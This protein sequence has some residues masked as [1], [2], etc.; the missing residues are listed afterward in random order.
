MPGPTY[1]VAELAA[2]LDLPFRGQ[3][4]ELLTGL[5]PLASAGKG[6]LSF[7]SSVKFKSSLEQSAASAVIVHPDMADL[8]P[9]NVLLSTNPYLSY[10]RVSA[11]FDAWQRPRL[12]IHPSAVV[13]S[14]QVHP[15]ASV[16]ANCVI[17]AGA[18]IAEGCVIGPGT[19]IG[20][21]VR[22]GRNCLLHANVT[23]YHSVSMGDDC[24]I[25]SGTVIGADG[26]GF[27]PSDEG[28]IKIHQLGS[29]KIGKRVEIGAN[30]T[31][32]RGAL[33]DTIIGNGVILDDQT[34]IA[35]NVEIGDNTAMAGCCQVAGS[36]KIG[37]NCTFAGNVGV[38]GHV[39]IADNVQ[40]TARSLV[41]KS[42]DKPGS[43]SGGV[44]AMASNLWRKN[45]ARFSKLDELH[46]R[47]VGLEKQL[48]NKEG[49]N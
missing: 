22:L 10:A 26:F 27:A 15:S 14:D 37:K 17:E 33:S 12:G 43:Y 13:A 36:T 41:S 8:C 45:F 30:S 32:D 24:V 7:L 40:I 25:H 29:V 42:I 39:E 38:I 5:A 9:T 16:G 2:T 3:G 18:E 34:M 35:H 11:L 23:V 28:W 4:D 31:I 21:N 1:S 46:R 20:E 49:K 48:K 44:I 6:E 19:V 47:V